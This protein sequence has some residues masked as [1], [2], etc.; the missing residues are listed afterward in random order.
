MLQAESLAVESASRLPKKHEEEKRYGFNRFAG[1]DLAGGEKERKPRAHLVP[2]LDAGFSKRVVFLSIFCRDME[3][4]FC[5]ARITFPVAH[6]AFDMRGQMIS[7]GKL[8]PGHFAIVM[9]GTPT[10]GTSVTVIWNNRYGNW[11]A[12]RFQR[13]SGP[14]V[15]T[16]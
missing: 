13:T 7:E 12:S 11:D 1:L 9:L 15:L 8:S 5:L 6:G 10:R 4:T 16:A 3:L 2:G 14:V